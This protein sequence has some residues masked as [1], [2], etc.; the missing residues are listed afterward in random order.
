MYEKRISENHSGKKER[1]VKKVS[2]RSLT[3]ALSQDATIV[4]STPV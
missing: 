3:F 4:V 1:M 2:L